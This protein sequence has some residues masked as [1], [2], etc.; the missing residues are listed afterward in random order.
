MKYKSWILIAFV[1]I[2]IAVLLIYHQ[3]TPNQKLPSVSE[4]GFEEYHVEISAIPGYSWSHY[5]KEWNGTVLVNYIGGRTLEFSEEYIRTMEEKGNHPLVKMHPEFEER[6]R[7][8]DHFCQFYPSENNYLSFQIPGRYLY[9][10]FY[11]IASCLPP[12]TS[13]TQWVE[14]FTTL[15][16]FK[17][18]F[19]WARTAVLEYRNLSLAYCLRNEAFIARVFQTYLKFYTVRHPFERL[20]SA[21]YD[22]LRLNSSRYERK[23]G[24]LIIEYN[25]LQ[26]YPTDEAKLIERL[27]EDNASQT[28]EEW[29]LSQLKRMKRVGRSFNLTFLEFVT[30]ITKV[31]YR[32]Y[33]EQHWRP[34]VL[35]CNPCVLKYD[36]IMKFETIYRD[37]NYF[38]NFV[39]KEK[40]NGPKVSFPKSKITITRERCN[41]E[42]SNVPLSIR[43]KLYN[44]FEED[45]IFYNYTTSIDNPC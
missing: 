16:E 27:R 11:Q 44:M 24:P 20:I 12:K 31:K 1:V 43:N 7:R 17:A 26:G 21:F 36:V 22:K 10:E 6:R 18:K 39:T 15:A 33:L 40:P 23:Y 4:F 9:N 8:L 3:L 28:E 38:L 42:F 13:S 41:K 45:F 2:Q 37:S 19:S 14:I 29:I 30:Y 32:N 5:K 35:L 25:Y 34:M